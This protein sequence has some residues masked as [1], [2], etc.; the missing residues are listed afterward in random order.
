M[1][2]L[3]R[4]VGLLEAS[5]YGVGL[6]LGAGIYAI[7]GEAVAETGE[8]IIV[9]FLLA[10]GV[11]TFTGLSY[12]ELA[13]RYPKG[14][15]E[16]LYAWAAFE[17]KRLSEVTAIFRV[18]TGIIAA[19]AVA[20]AFGQYF[21]AFVP[22]SSVP[23]AIGVL[24]VMSA[25]NFWGIETSAR[26]NL[27]FTAIEIAGLLFIIVIGIRTWGSVEITQFEH[28]ISGV[29]SATFLLFF[30]YTGFES[31]VNIAEEMKTP[32][33]TIPRAIGISIGLS[34]V[35]YLLVGLSALGLV[36][37][38]VL[39]DSQ[40][41]L[42]AV[43]LAGWGED[44]FVVLSAIALFATANTVLILLIST[45]R[46]TY[47]ISKA[48]YNSFPAVFA[49]VHPKR[50][51]PYIAVSLV[52]LV[53][54]PFALMGDLGAVAELANLAL[55]AVFVIVNLSLLKL[56]YSGDAQE[57]G[58]RAPLNIGRFSITAFLGLITSVGLILF[59]LAEAV[60]FSSW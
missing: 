52:A 49:R 60:R 22:L 59:Y 43:A 13:S 47:G 26:I 9:S 39:G 37:W 56:R 12:A 53:T 10:A 5:V 29:F 54:I 3:K 8:S 44:A 45:S 1:A 41:P 2:E 38:Q 57:T 4:A 51:T 18:L 55:L 19:A 24:V 40:A 7:L 20:L 32:S 23:V 31:L 27:L 50:K 16:Y 36:N 33:S 58:Y 35:V 46:V 30:A 42:A 14:E 25:I 34:T 28:G 6:I 17:N 48:E 21:A 15:G 11:A